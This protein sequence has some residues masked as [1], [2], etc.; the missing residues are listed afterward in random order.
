MELLIKLPA[1]DADFIEELERIPSVRRRYQ[2]RFDADAVVIFLV[3][4]A[5]GAKSIELTAK[6]IEET[7]TS[8]SSIIR[9]I[10]KRHQDNPESEFTVYLNET[11]I[12][13]SD[14]EVEEVEK[15]I[16]NLTDK[17]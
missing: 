12:I 11:P 3:T 17:N 2:E 6:S 7:I 5:V 1:S 4:I 16:E 10:S 13:T 8:I 15:A 14:M 9:N